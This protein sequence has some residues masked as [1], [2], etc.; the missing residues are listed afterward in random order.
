MTIW[1][2]YSVIKNKVLICSCNLLTPA[3]YII[4]LFLS[5]IGVCLLHIYELMCFMLLCAPAVAA[6]AV[7]SCPVLDSSGHF[8]L[9]AAWK[10]NVASKVLYMY[11]LLAFLH[12]NIASSTS[13][14]RSGINS[15]LQCSLYMMPKWWISSY[16]AH[17]RMCMVY[18]E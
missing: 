11:M 17:I 12:A 15:D 18:T 3:N 16:N 14:Q 10:V 9:I 5:C 13:T 4:S 2:W 7:Q 8:Y 6:L 1:R